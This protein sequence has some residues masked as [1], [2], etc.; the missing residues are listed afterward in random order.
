MWDFFISGLLIPVG[1]VI[2]LIVGFAWVSLFKDVKQ[3]D[4]KQRK[5]VYY[6]ILIAIFV[7]LVIDILLTI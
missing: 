2:T 5:K 6:F 7:L 3:R 4:V 1:F